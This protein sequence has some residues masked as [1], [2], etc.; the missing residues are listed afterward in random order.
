MVTVEDVEADVS[1]DFGRTEV[2]VLVLCSS[3]DS[4]SRVD[5]VMEMDEREELSESTKRSKGQGCLCEGGGVISLRRGGGRERE[6]ADGL[7]EVC[8]GGG[9]SEGGVEVKRRMGMG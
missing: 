5:D 7:E 3:S 9:E 1:R 2:T 4:S 6:L 8:A